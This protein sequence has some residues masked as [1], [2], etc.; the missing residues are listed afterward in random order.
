MNE[1]EKHN[2][3]RRRSPRAEVTFPVKYRIMDQSGTTQATV[4]GRAMNVSGSGL[5][6]HTDQPVEIGSTLAAEFQIPASQSEIVA[7]GRVI[8]SRPADEG[9]FEV[10][11]EFWWLGWRDENAQRALD[12]FVRTRLKD[13]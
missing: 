3:E 2:A 5:R 11:L 8:W 12:D 9:G 10:G 6:F 4:S 1:N 7:V 13:L